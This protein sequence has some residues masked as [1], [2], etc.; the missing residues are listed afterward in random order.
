LECQHSR[1]HENKPWF[2]NSSVVFIGS[3]AFGDIGEITEMDLKDHIRTIPD[4][5]KPGILFYDISTL[6]HNSK[7]WK[8]AIDQL[9]ERIAIYEPEVL[10][11]IEARGFLFAAPIAY[12]LGCGFAMIRKKSKLPGTTISHSYALEYGTDTIEIQSDA[13][14]NGQKVVVVDDILAT[15]G[16]ISGAVELLNK[17][18]ASIQAVAFLAELSFLGGR[19]KF[20]V[21]CET[22][23]TYEE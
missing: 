21:P 10:L 11:G 2:E 7:A 13:V 20:E 12:K 9:S 3:L 4:F 16:T 1:K 18:D 14:T 5:P 19:D 8:C 15:G 6:L 23:L 22:L 17:M